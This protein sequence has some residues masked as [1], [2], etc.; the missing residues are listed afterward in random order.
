L[1]PGP[2]AMLQRGASVIVYD[3]W[4]YADHVR[5]PHVG[6]V[7]A[8]LAENDSFETIDRLKDFLDR[9]AP[10][11][12]LAIVNIHDIE[13]RKRL[14]ELGFYFVAAQTPSYPDGSL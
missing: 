3:Y 12:V 8:E 10:R 9:T 6:A 11:F 4:P 14:K 1:R 5:L 7:F 13:K 2:Q